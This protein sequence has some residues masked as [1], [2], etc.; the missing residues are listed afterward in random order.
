MAAEAGAE[1]V[2]AEVGAEAEAA[3]EAEATEKLPVLE[4]VSLRAAPPLRRGSPRRPRTRGRR[5]RPPRGSPLPL[6]VELAITWP[7]CRWVTVRARF[8]LAGKSSPRTQTLSGVWYWYKEARGRARR[9]RRRQLRG[10]RARR[11]RRRRRR[12]RRDAAGVPG[13]LSF[14]VRLGYDPLSPGL[15]SYVNGRMMSLGVAAVALPAHDAVQQGRVLDVLAVPAGV[16]DG[17]RLPAPGPPAPV[18]GGVAS[19]RPAATAATVA[20]TIAKRNAFRTTPLDRI[21][22]AGGPSI[23]LSSG[24]E[25]FSR[26]TRAQCGR[27]QEHRQERADRPE[28]RNCLAWCAQ[29]EVHRHAH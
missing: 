20:A 1:A 3:A 25:G 22:T 18:P 26:R 4:V 14:G 23:A 24:P 29:S 15:G 9:V 10:V 28:G 16:A 13:R 7:D 27:G 8:V 21:A 17:H 5:P 11:R 6:T 2:A 12:G 19:A